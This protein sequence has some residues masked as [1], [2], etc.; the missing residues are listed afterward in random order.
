MMLC[1]EAFLCHSVVKH[2]LLE[3]E[4]HLNQIITSSINTK[5]QIVRIGLQLVMKTVNNNSHN[6]YT[7]IYSYLSTKL[8]VLVPW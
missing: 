3:L 4:Q 7:I 5:V 2:F 1:F 8:L 6:H